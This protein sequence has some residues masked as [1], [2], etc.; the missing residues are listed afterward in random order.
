MPVIGAGADA[1]SGFVGGGGEGRGDV[2]VLFVEVPKAV[3][4]D[5]GADVYVVEAE[6]GAAEDAVGAVTAVDGGLEGFGSGRHCL[7]D[8]DGRLGRV[9]LVLS[10]VH[11]S[12][13][14]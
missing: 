10:G 6:G 5:V 11:V 7:S 3:V 8:G 13:F 1:V 12:W 2:V 14:Q 4:V 9:A